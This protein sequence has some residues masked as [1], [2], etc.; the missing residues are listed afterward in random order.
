MY[1][2]IREP[3]RA[4]FEGIVIIADEKILHEKLP[5]V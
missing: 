2:E 4:I 1:S 3:F 5:Q